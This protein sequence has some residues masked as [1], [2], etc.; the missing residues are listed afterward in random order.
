MKFMTKYFWLTFASLTLIVQTNPVAASF[1]SYFKDENG[2]TKW[3]YVANFSS[4]VLIILLSVTAIVLFFSRREVSRTNKAL[5]QMND[6]L[7]ERVKERTATLDESNQKLTETNA[8]LEGEV[9]EHLK[10]TKQL[11]ASESYIKSI[12]ESMPIMLVGLNKEDQVTQWNPAAVELTGIKTSDAMGKD[13]WDAYPTLPL[14]RERVHEAID[15]NEPVHVR[16]SQRGQSHF[17]ITIY[18]LENF[19][20]TG[21]VILVEDVT[22]VVQS[23]N[24]LIEKDKLSAM[25]E[26][27]SV[28]AYDINAPLKR[29]VEAVEKLDCSGDKQANE[30]A[31][32]ALQKQSQRASAIVDN[33][34]DFSGASPDGIAPHNIL[35][36]IDH[37]IELSNDIFAVN[38]KPTFADI[39]IER[40]YEENL[41]AIPGFKSELQQVFVALLRY[42]F[43]A[44][45]QVDKEQRSPKITI[46]VL[47]SYDA[48]WIK[49]SHN[50]LGIGLDEQQVIFEPFFSDEAMDDEQKYEASQRLSFPY[51]IITQ[52]HQGKMAITSN[53]DI[54]TTFHLEL[55]LE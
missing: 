40:L 42:S 53:V 28:M 25:G 17:E 54:G 9:A 36:I 1:I 49:I 12:L 22:Q 38:D 14:P 26:L 50:G 18:P 45:R 35:E 46:Q 30:E 23:E 21:L 6:L 31:I 39:E 44:I 43:H 3:Q 16:S 8:L 55:P 27:S 10:T 24:K 32:E 51:F 15:K 52:H 11:Q 2:E 20:Q 13:L 37:S 7:E 34:L 48:L 47:T 41:P 4:G 33:L 5:K 29:I 19:I